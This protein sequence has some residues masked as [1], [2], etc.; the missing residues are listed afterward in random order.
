MCGRFTLHTPESRIREAF[1]LEHEEPLGLIPR[2]NI[3]PSQPIPII[4]DT[5]TGQEMVMARWGLVPHWSKEPKTRYSTINARI[6]T[7]AEKPV[8]RSSF[9]HRRCLIPADGFYEW[10]VL[11]GHKIPHYI[12]PADGKVFAFA[13]LWDHWEGDGKRLESCSILVMP[14]NEVMKSLHERMPAIIAP[15]HYDLW[16]DSRVTDK[17]EIMGY[18]N[19]APSSQLIAYPVSPWV[20]SPKHDDRRCIAP[21]GE[22][23]AD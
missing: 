17:A 9:Q 15:A 10:K 2:F 8:Y 21:A 12:R 11:N 16:L 23:I 14:A 20:N 13:G 6:E 5:E 1:H 7:V 3:A 22:P 18:L 19:S 4:R